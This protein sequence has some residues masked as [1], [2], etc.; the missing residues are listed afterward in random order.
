[1]SNCFQ[2]NECL[3]TG[4]FTIRRIPKEDSRGFF[5][6]FYCAN[7]FRELGLK[8]PI[9]QSNYTLTVGKGAIRGLHYQ[10]PPYS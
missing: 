4:L 3:L 8:Q 1:M 2:F 9:A 10:N 6:R 7:E 5:S